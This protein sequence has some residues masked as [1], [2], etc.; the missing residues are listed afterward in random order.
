MG[1]INY[2]QLRIQR[3]KFLI[4]EKSW[5]RTQR[6]LEKLPGK[7]GFGSMDQLIE[8]LRDVSYNAI[9]SRKKSY[10][11]PRQK[12]RTITPKIK[13]RVKQLVEAGKTGAY[14]AT[15]VKI[16]IPTVHNIKKGLGLVRA[17]NSRSS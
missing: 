1:K 16:S 3:Q 9:I 4:I 13:Q 17:R 8:A 14:I 10:L 11:K 5:V 12:R 6:E 2:E 7:F 15:H